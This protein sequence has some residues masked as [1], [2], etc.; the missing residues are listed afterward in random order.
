MFY[1]VGPNFIKLFTSFYVLWGGPVTYNLAKQHS[2]AP[3]GLALALFTRIIT[4][5]W[6]GLTGTNT[7]AYYEHS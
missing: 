6:K 7:L 1:S 3:L 5:S 4:L 2:G